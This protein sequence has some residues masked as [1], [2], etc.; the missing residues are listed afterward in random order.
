MQAWLAGLICL[1]CL[2][3]A[4]TVIADA[5]AGLAPDLSSRGLWRRYEAPRANTL[6]GEALLI[7]ARPA[8]LSAELRARFGIEVGDG[9]LAHPAGAADALAAATSAPA[10]MSP[11]TL[12]TLTEWR[13]SARALPEGAEVA[14]VW[15]GEGAPRLVVGRYDGR[16]VW[17]SPDGV[18]LGHPPA[19]WEGAPTLPLKELRGRAW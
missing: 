7:D 8:P 19:S 3:Y 1:G 10:P 16:W 11:H 5:R 4:A 13:G 14:L 9:A 12:N 18:R 15:A 6:E 17:V 2:T